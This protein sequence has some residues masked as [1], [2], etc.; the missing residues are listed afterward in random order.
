MTAAQRYIAA[1]TDADGKSITALGASPA[2]AEARLR[3]NRRFVAGVAVRHYDIDEMP[4][5]PA[6]DQSIH[7]AA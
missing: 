3:K 1:A 5:E 6:N 2:D 7:K 4:L